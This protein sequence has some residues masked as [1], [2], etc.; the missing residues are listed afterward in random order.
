MKNKHV[1]G[2]TV[3]VLSV[4]GC[5]TSPTGG[6]GGYYAGPIQ[7]YDAGGQQSGQDAGG[8]GQDASTVPQPGASPKIG[9]VKLAVFGDNVFPT[10]IAHLF[11]TTKFADKTLQFVNGVTVNNPGTTPLA[12]TLNAELQGFSFPASTN[13][14]VPAGGST[15]VQ[16]PMTF[17]MDALYGVSATQAANLV[18]TLQVN[19][20]TKDTLTKQVQIAPKNTVFWAVKDDTGKYQDL[21]AFVGVFVTPHD[22]AMEIDKLITAAAGQSEFNGMIGYQALG[23]GTNKYADVTPGDCKEWPVLHKAGDKVGVN[24]NVTC[25]ACFSYNSQ[26]YFMDDTNHQIFKSD[27]A[28]STYIIGSNELGS[29]KDSTY[30]P[31]D[32]VYWHMACNPSSNDSDRQYSIART[33]G[34]NEA[35]VDQLGALFMALKNKGMVYTSVA[36]AFFDSAQN[37]KTPSESLQTGSQNCIDGTLVFASALES[38]GMESAIVKVPGHAFVAVKVDP[39]MNT[40]YPIETTMV[41]SS[42]V[43]AAMQE[44]LKKWN[45][46]QAEGTMQLIKIK[47]LREAGINPAPF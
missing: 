31:K 41:S 20:E 46:Y 25:S 23:A 6:G 24:V 34:A 16:V 10:Y 36:A 27:P 32:G 8:T 29:F 22:K 4:S 12:A 17:K 7:A 9:E 13:V 47:E 28:S 18:L 21:S 1:L 15:K 42:T 19:G 35:A 43:A 3:L 11:G 2:F 38:L 14:N 45:K 44:G 39:S 40:W 5:A 33:I 37:I 26:Y 30:V